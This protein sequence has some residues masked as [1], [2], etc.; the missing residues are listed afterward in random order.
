VLDSVWSAEGRL[1]IPQQRESALL[2]LRQKWQQLSTQAKGADDS[3]ERRLARRVLNN[4]SVGAS[5]TDEDYLKIIR[6]YRIGR[7]GRG[8]GQ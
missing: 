7:G 1:N 8:G 4:L 3:A 2:D 6:E 5:T